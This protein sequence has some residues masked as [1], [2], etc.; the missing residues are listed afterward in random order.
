MNKKYVIYIKTYLGSQA[1][2]SIV[3]LLSCHHLPLQL[4]S[5][6]LCHPFLFVIPLVVV[7]MACIANS[8]CCQWLFV[9]I[10]RGKYLKTNK[11]IS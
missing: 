5:F 3:A 10:V 2:L 7:V 4:A 11:K 9:V 8:S 1:L 6:S